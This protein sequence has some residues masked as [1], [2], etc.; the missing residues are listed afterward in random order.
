M[1][2]R[3]FQVPRGTDIPDPLAVFD[4][5]GKYRRFSVPETAEAAKILWG[6]T[7][8]TAIAWCAVS[9]RCDGRTDEYRFWFQVFMHLQAHQSDTQ[10]KA[11]GAAVRPRSSG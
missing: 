10:A 11:A 7:A 8:V 9:A 5:G 1:K 3:L 6:D 2:S 4:S